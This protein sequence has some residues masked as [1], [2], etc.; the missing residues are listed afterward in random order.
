M[1]D[2]IAGWMCLGSVFMVPWDKSDTQRAVRK[3]SWSFKGHFDENIKGFFSVWKGT[4]DSSLGMRIC[5]LLLVFIDAVPIIIAI[6]SLTH[7]QNNG[8][9]SESLL[10]LYTMYFEETYEIMNFGCLCRLKVLSW[11][12]FSVNKTEQWCVAVTI[13]YMMSSCCPACQRVRFGLW[14]AASKSIWQSDIIN[15]ACSSHV[16]FKD[17]A[18][19]IFVHLNRGWLHKPLDFN[20][21]V[22][23]LYAPKPLFSTV[24]GLHLCFL[25][26]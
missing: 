14:K 5:P 11:P 13:V 7:I 22:D 15:F 16:P 17:Y 6:H 23:I 4:K 21:V 25:I 10:R 12:P 26:F 8:R 9:I 24:K 20:L 1:S 18:Y 19:F 2:L 3:R